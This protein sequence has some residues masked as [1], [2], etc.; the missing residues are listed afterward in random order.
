M[1][2]RLFEEDKDALSSVHTDKQGMTP[3]HRS[4]IFL[5]FNKCSHNDKYSV[6]DRGSFIVCSICL[7][8]VTGG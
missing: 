1:V 7:H 5:M 3:L 6:N 2:K 4:G 8:S